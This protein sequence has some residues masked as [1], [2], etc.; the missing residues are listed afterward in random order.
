MTVLM[1]LQDKVDNCDVAVEEIVPKPLLNTDEP[2]CPVGE[3]ACGT[4]VCLPTELFCDG[5]TDCSDGSDEG[6]CDPGMLLKKEHFFLI[7]PIG[8]LLYDFIIESVLKNSSQ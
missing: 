6:W 8:N 3:T 5:H 7:G 4:G 2:I 1:L